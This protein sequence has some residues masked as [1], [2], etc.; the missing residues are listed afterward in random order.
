M[1]QNMPIVEALRNYINSTVARFHMPGHKGGAGTSPTIKDFLGADT[2]LADVTNIPGMDDLHQPTGIIRKAQELAAQ[3]FGAE[4]SYFLIN[5]SSC[6]LMALIM[7]TCR[8]GDKILVPRN[9][10]RSILSGIILSGTVP[11]FFRPFYDRELLLP[12]AVAPE[13]IRFTLAEHPDARA[14]FVISPTYNGIT[15]D[16]AKIAEEVHRYGIPLLVDEAHGPHLGLHEGLPPRA[17]DCGADAVVHGTHKILTSFTQASMLHVKGRRVDRARLEQSLRVLQSTSP[18]YLLLASLDAARA[19]V[20]ARGREMAATAL[21][22]AEGLRRAVENIPGVT[23]FG[24]R[25]AVARGAAGLDRT[26]VTISVKNLGITGVK[27]E[28]WLR[29]NAF[30]QVEMSDVFN[31]L[32]IITAGNTPDDVRRLVSGLEAIS[33]AANKEMVVERDLTRVLETALE[34]PEAPLVVTPREAFFGPS[35]SVPLEKA[36]GMVAAETVACYP[37][38]IPVLCPGEK[39]TLEIIEYLNLVRNLGMHF[40]GPHDPTVEFIRV[41]RAL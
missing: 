33:S 18:S 15:S 34:A 3:T 4:D 1:A 8:P 24:E 20:A 19:D 16:I 27:A 13:I 7:A 30:I 28:V 2:L 22:M 31:L 23:A 37:P 9:I 6:G 12:L 29:E 17:L 11:V 5:G 26:K 41:L 21:N 10:H 35:L 14:V 39:I 25:W 40:Q 32:V 38:G 36:A